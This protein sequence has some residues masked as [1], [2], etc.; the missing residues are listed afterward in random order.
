MFMRSST[1]MRELF[2]CVEEDEIK[3]RR[4]TSKLAS[5]ETKDQTQISRYLNPF[6][7]ER[8]NFKQIKACRKPASL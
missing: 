3:E 1:G 5:K 6:Q 2:Y 7:T 8:N 4:E